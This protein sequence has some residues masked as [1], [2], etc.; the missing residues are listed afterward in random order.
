MEDNSALSDPI[1]SSNRAK[2]IKN[3]TICQKV[4]KRTKKL[5]QCWENLT[6]CSERCQKKSMKHQEIPNCPAKK[7]VGERLKNCSICEKIVELAYRCKYKENQKDWDFVCRPCWPK[8][9]FCSE[10]TGAFLIS[11]N[12]INHG[13]LL[14]KLF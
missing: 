5:D 3:C 4:I 14:P 10:S 6:T 2:E 7:G 8:G 12:K 13:I 11:S 9:S 1:D